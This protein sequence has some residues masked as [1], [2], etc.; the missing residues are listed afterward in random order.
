MFQVL[1]VLLSR[2][3][4]CFLLTPGLKQQ[5]SA[6]VGASCRRAALQ[7]FLILRVRTTQNKVAVILSPV[8]NLIISPSQENSDNLTDEWLITH[9]YVHFL[10]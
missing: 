2:V 1:F 9:D 8:V 6:I 10:S 7:H 3:L 5:L 4:S